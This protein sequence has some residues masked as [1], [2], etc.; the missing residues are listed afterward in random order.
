MKQR[1]ILLENTTEWHKFQ[2][3]CLEQNAGI[4]DSRSMWD[5]HKNAMIMDK[6]L[7]KMKGRLLYG[8]SERYN[9][10]IVIGIDFKTEQDL[11]H[12]KLKFN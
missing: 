9:C 7:K 8:R 1:I 5:M 3:W 4:V 12:F 2:D 10:K 11:V 6:L